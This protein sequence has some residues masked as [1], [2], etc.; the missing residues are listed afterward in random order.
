MQRASNS[1]TGFL[2]ADVPGYLSRYVPGSASW[3][4]LGTGDGLKAM[5][6]RSGR[7]KRERF[8]TSNMTRGKVIDLTISDDEETIVF[9][10]GPKRN[11]KRKSEAIDLRSD[12]EPEQAD[13]KR[14]PLGELTQEQFL[15]RVRGPKAWVKRPKYDHDF[16]QQWRSGENAASTRSSQKLPSRKD[17]RSFFTPP[18]NNLSFRTSES[19]R[20]ASADNMYGEAGNARTSLSGKPKRRAAQSA[21]DLLMKKATEHI[22]SS[23]DEIVASSSAPNR[24]AK[25]KMSTR[26]IAESD[27]EEDVADVLSSSGVSENDQEVSEESDARLEKATTAK[28]SKPTAAKSK[29]NGRSSGVTGSRTRMVNL[30]RRNGGN[31]LDFSLPLIS[32]ITEIFQDLTRRALDLGFDKTVRELANRPIRVAT[33]CSGTESPLLALEMISDALKHRGNQG[34]LIDHLFSAE[35]VTFKQAYIERNFNPPLIFRDITELTEAVNDANPVATTAYGAKA[36]IPSDVDLVIAGTSCVDFSSRNKH[37]KGLEDGGESGDTFKAVLAYCA[38]YKPAIVLLEN[39]SKAPFDSMM[40][41]YEKAGYEVAGVH[42]DTKN[43]Y[44]PQ[45][46]QRGYLACFYSGVIGAK[47]A[48][49]AAKQ[50]VS[51]FERCKRSASAPIS[52]FLLPNDQLTRKH[53]LSD[54]APR[55]VDWSKCEITQMDYR[56]RLKLGSARPYTNWT[57]SGSLIPPDNGDMAFFRAR[58]EREN[59]TMDVGLLRKARPEAGGYDVRFKTRALDISQNVY[60][61]QDTN[62]SGVIGC[63]TPTGRPFLTDACRA[64][65]SKES[66]RLQGIPLHKISFTTESPAEI[67]DLAGNAMSSAVIGT[68]IISALMAGS[69]MM[70]QTTHGPQRRTKSQD[71]RQVEILEGNNEVVQS[72]NVTAPIDMQELVRNAECALRRCYCEG[73]VGIAEK[74]IQQCSDCGH[75]TCIACGGNARHNYQSAH[76]LSQARSA[77]AEFEHLVRSIFPVRLVFEPVELPSD[78]PADYRLSVAS[79]M[80]AKYHFQDVRRTHCWTITYCAGPRHRLE[81]VLGAATGPEWRLFAHADKSLAANDPLRALLRQPVLSSVASSCF[82]G[83]DWKLRVPDHTAPSMKIRGSGRQ[84]SS[85]FSRIGLPDFR[86][87]TLWEHIDIHIDS[88][89]ASVADGLN[90][91]YTHLP[92]CGTAS[93]A[94]YKRQNCDAHRP[95]YLFLDP[96]RIGPPD[97]DSFVFSRCKHVLE[98]DEVRPLVARVDPKWRPWSSDP[99]SGPPETTKTTLHLEHTW[100]ALPT[101]LQSVKPQ[102]QICAPEDM[103][104]LAQYKD[105]SKAINVLSATVHSGDVDGNPM[106]GDRFSRDNAWIFEAMRRCVPSNRWRPLHKAHDNGEC[107]FCAPRLPPLRWEIVGGEIKEYEDPAAAAN[108]ERSVKTRPPAIAIRSTTVKDN[109]TLNLGV[110]LATLAHRVHSRLPSA[111][112]RA[113]MGWRLLT[114]SREADFVFKPFKLRPTSGVDSFDGDLKMSVKLFPKQMQAVSWMRAQESGVEFD[115]E[116]I[117]EAVLPHLGWRAE[118]RGR[119][120]LNIR[121]GVC[122]DHPGFG[123]TI[124]SLALIQ[125]ELLESTRSAI[126]AGLGKR[127]AESISTAHLIP[128]AATLIAQ[129]IDEIENKLGTLDGVLSIRTAASLSKLTLDDFRKAKIII[130]NRNTLASDAYTERLAAFAGIPGPATSGRGLTQWL[131]FAAEQVPEHVQQ[132]TAHGESALKNLIKQKYRANLDSDDFRTVVPSRRLRGKDYVAAKSRSAQS[133]VK[134]PAAKDI[135]T[136][137]VGRPLFEMFFFNRIIMDEFH[138]FDPRQH[139]A[140]CALKADKRWL[141]S[142]TPAIGDFYEVAQMAKL[143]GVQLRIGSEDRASLKAQ[144][145][146]EL[147]KCQTDFERVNS[148]RH[149][150]SHTAQRHIYEHHG[151]FLDTFVR[152]NV[153]DF[154]EFKVHEHLAPIILD[155][156]HAALYAEV[157]Q[158]FNSLDMRIKKGKKREATDRDGRFADASISS[159]TAEEALAKLAAFYDRAGSAD[160]ETLLARRQEQAKQLFSK[161]PAHFSIARAEEPER[162]ASLQEQISSGAFGDDRITQELLKVMRSPGSTSTLKANSMLQDD[163]DLEESFKVKSAGSKTAALNRACKRLVTAKRSARFL[164]N[165]L[166]LKALGKSRETCDHPKCHGANDA[167]VFA[168]STLCGHKICKNCRND[169]K[170]HAG[171][172][173]PAP[174]CS[175]TQGDFDLLWISKLGTLTDKGSPYGAK[176]K[177]AISLLYGIEEKQE[178]AIMFV[179]FDEQIRE[180]K[181]ALEHAGI[182]STIVNTASEA[183]DLIADFRDS[184]GTEHQIT[185]I[186]LNASDETA[187]GSNLQNANHVIF[188]SPLLRDTQYSYEATN[189]QAIGRVRRYGQK[190]KIHV[191]RLVALYTIDVDILE[192]RERR[193]DAVTEEGSGS[194]SAPNLATKLDMCGKPALERTQ[195]VCEDGKYSLRPQSWLIRYGVD[196]D[197]VEWEK[198]KGKNRILGWDDFSSLIKFSRAY[199]EDD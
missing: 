138:Q 166:A 84:I 116:E 186:V 189:A 136:S 194:I 9:A 82:E 113:Q 163:S 160:L 57:E 112:M 73:P 1:S 55:E 83:T 50:W 5:H 31:G 168:V 14:T 71:V 123:K 88:N 59:D 16:L 10:S 27:Y 48:A 153:M 30:R 39:V 2:N 152:Q 41:D 175:A 134:R 95:M 61:D 158:Q 121:G 38:A 15:N 180:A 45:T 4:H 145:K 156:D 37:R 151:R 99:S 117:E 33:M 51:I 148:A 69:R 20:D 140:A 124:T 74:P 100:H 103:E 43:H 66:L 139:A 155:T 173:C 185:V 63:L 42:V 129:W 174:G 187:A 79:A 76:V 162:Y 28:K 89:F 172:Q 78:L 196:N 75:T 21:F 18:A 192:H 146:R 128:L 191:Y 44:L 181:A 161:L 97:K 7:P 150:T 120:P 24:R 118:V 198:V 8:F 40:E 167:S 26:K 19:A 110:N 13:S 114:T 137:H 199:T 143:L 157:A 141:L 135:D 98:Y 169:H 131:K 190:R 34:L 87:H 90:G 49:D 67:Q 6:C 115:L 47:R 182:R 119:T 165:V 92:H 56:Q 77:P 25:R 94:L 132:L 53:N 12:S 101:S 35:I 64:L 133:I 68:S 17:I 197:A 81:L 93:E 179:Q 149:Q 58:V 85:W 107:H 54:A 193:E 29:A 195:L 91:V 105:C 184:A 122:A 171:A 86:R 80:N 170:S 3:P 104:Q 62:P 130:V 183:G 70:Q 125:A 109:T 176:L 72:H 11:P 52:Y 164:L 106:H 96:D 60:M 127:Q 144:S 22:E 188:L 108:Y 154:A 147:Q 111:S 23:E 126:V 65:D 32:D 36:A 102:L 159:S 46:R 142:G 177:T 178:Q